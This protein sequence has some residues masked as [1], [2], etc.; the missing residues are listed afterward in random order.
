MI[1][2]GNE[3]KGL[4]IHSA[5][6]FGDCRDDWWN[7]DFLELMARRWR[8]DAVQCV[9][10]VGCGVGHWGMAL[11]SVLP[12]AAQ[13][14]GIDREAVWVEHAT[15]RARARGL[16]SRFHY[17]RGEAER[18]PFA[19]DSF[20]LT[21]CQTLLIH[22]SD[23]S[24]V[25]AEM[26]RVTKPGGLV[27]VAEPNNVAGALGMDS[28]SSQTNIEEIV[29]RVRL[30]LTCERGKRA[31]GEGDNSLGETVAGL[32][33]EQGL[34]DVSAFANDKVSTVVPPY[35]SDEQRAFAADLRDGVERNFWIWSEAET[36]RYFLAGGGAEREF[37]GLFE[38]ALAAGRRTERALDAG[39]YHGIFGGAFFLIGGRK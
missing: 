27:A 22:V 7:H 31:L 21:T 35:D 32:F 15:S 14:T 36:R 23:P 3:F 34:R 17:V 6:H 29:E 1:A 12:D 11:E 28:L 13:V 16:S 25:I 8:F 18:L 4:P 5:E 19:D 37:D 24:A 9:L 26:R 30:Q 20:D 39:A 10:D 33:A 2:M 38:R